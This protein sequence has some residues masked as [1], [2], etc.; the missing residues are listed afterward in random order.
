MMLYTP[1]CNVKYKIGLVSIL[2]AR[3]MDTVYPF[4][5]RQESVPPAM[6]FG[7]DLE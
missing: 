4:V 1:R 5:I 3:T 6:M 7:P 2:K